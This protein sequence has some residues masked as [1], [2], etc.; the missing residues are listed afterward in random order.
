MKKKKKMDPAVLLARENKRKK[1][2]EKQM[3][4]LER[5][6]RRLKP[7][8]EIDGDPKIQKEVE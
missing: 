3:K 6:G 7:V 8:D 4:R 5:F 1:K 2:I